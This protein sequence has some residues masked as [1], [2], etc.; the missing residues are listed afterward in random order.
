MGPEVNVIARWQRDRG[1]N[2]PGGILAS[3]Y[4]LFSPFPPQSRAY[5]I[6][7]LF[8]EMETMYAEQSKGLHDAWGWSNGTKQKERCH[9]AV[10]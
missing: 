10:S 1:R 7:A 8:R 2:A 6:L 5:F 4:E 9:Y 3:S